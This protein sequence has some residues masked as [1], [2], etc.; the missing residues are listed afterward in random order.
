VLQ[1]LIIFGL[2]GL[3]MFALSRLI[4][5]GDP[6]F[7]DDHAVISPDKWTAYFVV[8]VG[9]LVLV[10]SAVGLAKGIYVSGFALL[11]GV[12]LII[13]MAPSLT[14]MHN[15]SW[16]DDNLE[17]PSSTFGFTLGT[18]RSS[19]ALKDVVKAGN[20]WTGY[21]FIEDSSGNRVYWSYLHRGQLHFRSHLAEK[22]GD[23]PLP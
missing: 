10:A 17:G 13:F 18:K 11:F 6:K 15:V 14:D 1:M 16:D 20:T 23:I 4:G 22:C 2:T 8:I 9:I 5:R 3:S 19:I 21:W 12:A 7:Q